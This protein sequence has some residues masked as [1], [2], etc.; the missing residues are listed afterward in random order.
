MGCRISGLPAE[1]FVPFF[2]MSDADLLARA[3]RRHVATA[4][5]TPMMPPCRVSLRDA[6][7]PSRR[8]GRS[9]SGFPHRG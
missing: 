1:P 8:S 2:A 3:A 9:S 6:S 4:A 7:R 5:D